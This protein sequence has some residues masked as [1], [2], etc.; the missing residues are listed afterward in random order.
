VDG[1]TKK[2]ESKKLFNFIITISVIGVIALFALL[3]VKLLG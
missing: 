1:F 2:S 3:A